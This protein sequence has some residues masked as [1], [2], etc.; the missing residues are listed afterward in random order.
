MNPYQ[1]FA[2]VYDRFMTNMPTADWIVFIERIWAGSNLKQKLI[3]DIGCGTGAMSL[4]L[5]RK[6]YNIIGIDVSEDMLSIARQK[7]E[8]EGLNILF[9]QQDIHSFE[10]YG[11]VDSIICICDVINYLEENELRQVFSLMYN[12]LNPGGLLIFD[13]STEYKFRELLADNS[14][15]EID[16]NAAYIWENSYSPETHINEYQVTFFIADE[17]GKYERFEEF[18][19]LR[20]FDIPEIQNALESSGFSDIKTYDADSFGIIKN[21]SERIFFTALK[22]AFDS[23]TQVK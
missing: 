22:L 9:L 18:H 11:T 17:T 4:P 19:T 20:A 14:F 21:E 3:L 1:V 10:L 7:A 5:A 13:I 6:G 8:S 23:R 15:C 12:Y 16:E 2:R